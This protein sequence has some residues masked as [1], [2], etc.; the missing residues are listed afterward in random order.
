MNQHL[1]LALQIEVWTQEAFILWG[2][3]WERIAC[4]IRTRLAEMGK[5]ERAKLSTE[6]AMTLTNSVDR[7]IYHSTN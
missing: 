2:D 4:H 1:P 7:E 5:I 3:D 6:A